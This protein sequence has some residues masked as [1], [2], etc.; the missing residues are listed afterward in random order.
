MATPVPNAP[1]LIDLA[2]RMERLEKGADARAAALHEESKGFRLYLSDLL[3]FEEKRGRILTFGALGFVGIILTALVWHINNL[4]NVAMTQAKEAA[5]GAVERANERIRFAKTEWEDQL[6]TAVSAEA[7]GAR[8]VRTAVEQIRDELKDDLFTETLVQLTGILT[9]V[10][11]LI[12][13]RCANVRGV[14]PSM[15]QAE[16][17]V[18][19]RYTVERF[20]ERYLPDLQQRQMGR[21]RIQALMLTVRGIQEMISPQPWRAIRTFERA[22]Y[23][24]RNLP[25]PHFLTALT[26][27]WL[28]HYVGD[29]VFDRQDE[30]L[31][32]L[33]ILDRLESQE[34][35][36][37]PEIPYMRVLR[38][39]IEASKTSDPD[40][41]TIK[42]EQ[43]LETMLAEARRFESQ[44]G[45]S[46]PQIECRTGFVYWTLKKPVD[47]MKG[48][49]HALE[50]DPSY[51]RA[52]NALLNDAT[53]LCT[54]D[55]LSLQN[56]ILL[57]GSDAL[58]R[59]EIARLARQL[60]T[61]PAF[62][63]SMILISTVL[64]A[65]WAMGEAAEARIVAE[66]YCNV[67]D[68]KHFLWVQVQNFLSTSAM[69]V[70]V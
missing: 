26:Y 59:H 14:D 17:V 12:D 52:K 61:H 43:A 40:A 38:W 21:P 1:S 3:G 54:R 16:D 23:M 62:E 35:E 29:G 64:E 58:A 42:R 51:I 33:A 18:E 11:I 32:A 28:A 20:L 65:F 49:K 7:L 5:D 55:D 66:L 22:S 41:A 8:A 56:A 53:H 60:R 24:D 57:Y 39:L 67:A 10:Q 15:M 63:T 27:T 25:D 37:H 4:V 19:L 2:A 36:R 46:H 13:E 34:A 31:K 9:R 47:S 68:D 50:L 44:H 30:I 69:P 6:K 70:V 48:S 45:H